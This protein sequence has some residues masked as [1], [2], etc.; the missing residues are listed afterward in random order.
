MT[1]TPKEEQTTVEQFEPEATAVEEPTAESSTADEPAAAP[2]VATRR[3]IPWERVF[4]YG[5]VPAL[6]LVLAVAG[7]YLFWRNY[8]ADA[9]EQAREDSVA[10]ARSIAISMLTYEPQSV[11][12]QLGAAKEQL[13]GTFRDTYSSL[14]DTVVVPGAKERQ[15]SAVTDVPAA[16]SVSAEPDHA[17]VLLFVNQTVTVGSEPP[18]NTASSVRVTLDKVGDQWRVSEFQPI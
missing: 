18:T 12:Q 5:V 9:A 14:I 3:S 11:E 13:T 6:A 8:T 4:A 16:A 7:G 15:I 10:A 2:A 17:V 1:D